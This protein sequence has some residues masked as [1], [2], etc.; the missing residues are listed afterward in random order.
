M[1]FSTS[2]VFAS[3][4]ATTQ[5]FVQPSAK[6]IS[7]LRMSENMPEE[8]TATEETGDDVLETPSFV[9][10]P[11]DLGLPTMSQALP[12]MERPAAL[13]GSLVGDV[14]FDPLGF[15]KNKEDL[16]NYREAEIKHARLAMLAAAGWP[17]S[18]LFDAKIANTLG[19]DPVVDAS[20]RAPSVLN[21]G[22]G[23][24][25]PI[26]WLLCL[27]GAAAIDLLGQSQKGKPGYFPGNIGFDPL[28][29]YPKDQAGQERMQLA[30]LKNGRLAMIAITAFAVQEFVTKVGVV[31]ETP[32]FF[33]PI[34]TTIH[35]YTNAGYIYH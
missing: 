25:S 24:V 14:G 18:E 15:A 21:G 6:V 8:P 12:F 10:T 20:A 13:D 17:L 11:A 35:E 28:G 16:L 27:G 29:L 5:A 7:P 3:M 33:K 1:K 26:Y 22:L 9:E 2:I 23:Q 34:A 31:D 4:A 30:E 32:L 19:L